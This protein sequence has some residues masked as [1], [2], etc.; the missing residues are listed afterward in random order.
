VGGSGHDHDQ[1]QADS[2]QDVTDAP[3]AVGISSLVW[4][5]LVS[6]LFLAILASGWLEKIDL[7]KL[8]L[9]S[10]GEAAVPQSIGA[11]LSNSMS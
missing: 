1:D 5:V 11:D 3:S 2:D 9:L 10:S 8:K 4:L 7:G 6:Q